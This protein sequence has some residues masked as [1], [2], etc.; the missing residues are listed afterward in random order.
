MIIESVHVRNFRSVID[1]VLPCEECTALDKPAAIFRRLGVPTYVLWD[2]DHGNKDARPEDNHRLLRLMN[3]TV[4]DWPN[5]VADECACFSSN[6]EETLCK[7]IGA[8]EFN[9]WLSEFQTAFAIRK[10]AHALKNPVVISAIMKKARENARCSKTVE[11]IVSKI[12]ALKR[13]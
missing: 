10:R 11:Q 9:A 4:E 6:L 2:G 8:A 1:E 12:T 3:R 7:E 13:R 5:F